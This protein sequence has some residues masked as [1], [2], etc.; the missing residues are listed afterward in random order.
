MSYNIGDYNRG[1]M[2]ALI[3][4]MVFTAAF[5]I[6]VSFIHPGIHLHQLTNPTQGKQQV[7]MAQNGTAD[8]DVSDV[9]DPWNNSKAMLAHGH[10]VFMNNC[11]MC[12]GPQGLGN[13]PAAAGLNP[14]P[15]N[16][17]KGKWQK[18]G[19]RLDIFNVVTN[20]F[21]GSAM[22][23]FKKVLSFNDRWA[24]DHYVR[25]ITHNVVHK[26]GQLKAWLAS[27]KK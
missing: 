7:N 12:H 8:V 19:S 25:S 21:P 24:V 4:C 1:G 20:G 3:F 15:R 5:F 23:S 11:Q 22:P 9:K 10:T 14:H 6:Y 2:I 17:V 18:G 27:R 13:G 16:L 26:P